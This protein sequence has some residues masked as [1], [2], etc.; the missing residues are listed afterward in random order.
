VSN[1]KFKHDVNT[2]AEAKAL[3]EAGVS[4]L[5]YNTYLAKHG[6]DFVIVHW[7]TPIITFHPDGSATFDAAWV[8]RT[9]ANRMHHYKPEMVEGVGSRI[10]KDGRY[11]G[12][13]AVRLRNHPGTFDIWEGEKYRIFPDRTVVK[14]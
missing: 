4:D 3:Y 12:R 7:R 14:V 10:V 11:E 2:Y 8:S 13:Y 6:D 5:C 1:L 9:T